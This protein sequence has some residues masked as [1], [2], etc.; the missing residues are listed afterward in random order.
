MK[1]QT[2]KPDIEQPTQ[3]E[4]LTAFTSLAAAVAAG[5]SS[6]GPK[7]RAKP[8]VS[9]KSPNSRRRKG[10]AKSPGGIQ[11]R[12]GREVR[13]AILHHQPGRQGCSG[14]SLRGMAAHRGKA[15]A[16]EHFQPDQKEVPGA[17]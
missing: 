12:R 2:P 6:K 4:I 13:G 7:G 8:N 1:K 11:A 14:I 10:T 17:H 3:T 16:A 5:V 15:G 9:R